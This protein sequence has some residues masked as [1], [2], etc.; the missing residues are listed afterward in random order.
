MSLLCSGGG[1][2][3]VV[4]VVVVWW[5]SPPFLYQLRTD[6]PRSLRSLMSC[7]FCWLVAVSMLNSNS[8]SRMVMSLGLV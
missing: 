2:I 5:R 8:V 7:C 3:C 1:L 6:V 4:M